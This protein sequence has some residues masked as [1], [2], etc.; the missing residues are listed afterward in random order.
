M[1]TLMPEFVHPC[2]ECQFLGVYV[3]DNGI[4]FDLYHHSNEVFHARFGEGKYETLSAAVH[5]EVSVL[6][7]IENISEES[8]YPVLIARSRAKAIWLRRN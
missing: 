4:N 2:D 5:V 3:D 7:M 6:S 1:K 8:A